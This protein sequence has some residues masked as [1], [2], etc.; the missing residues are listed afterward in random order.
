MKTKKDVID[1]CKTF[2]NVFEDYPFGDDSWAAM[3][4]L[5]SRHG[6]AWI[7]ER[8]GKIWVN[9]KAEPMWGEFLRDTYQSVIPAYHMNKT[10]WNSLILDGS[11]PREE[12][13]NMIKESYNLCAKK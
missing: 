10:H 12:I 3:R 2:P 11:V 4:R 5:D 8:N 9:F 1:F 7:F 13:E 6:F